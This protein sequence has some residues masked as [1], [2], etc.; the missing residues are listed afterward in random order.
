MSKKRRRM[1]QFLTAA[2]IGVSTA[3]VVPTFTP[4]KTYAASQPLSVSHRARSNPVKSVS[5]RS[6]RTYRSHSHITLKRQIH[7]TG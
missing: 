2:A 4:A 6:Q 1:R 3:F 7:K 5:T